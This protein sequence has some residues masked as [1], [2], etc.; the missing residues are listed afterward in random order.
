MYIAEFCIGEPA[1]ILPGNGET[2]GN[3]LAVAKAA[4]AGTAFGRDFQARPFKSCQDRF[5]C[6]CRHRI[7]IK[8]DMHGER[9]ALCL[10]VAQSDAVCLFFDAAEGQAERGELLI[11]KGVHCLRAAHHD[12]IIPGNI[13]LK[14][15][16]ADKTA[17]VSL[18]LFVAED[19]NDFDLIRN[20]RIEFFFE[21]QV[22]FR[23]CSVKDG[24]FVSVR[25]VGDRLRHAVKRGDTAPSGDGDHMIRVL[26]RLITELPGRISQNKG[27]PHRRTVKQ[28]AA[29]EAAF[30]DGER[31]AAGER[32]FRRG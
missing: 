4:S 2:A 5:P 22:A 26:D 10:G 24:K 23:P 12:R 3:Q 9:I 30:F 7:G 32:L 1:L 14:Q 25:S 21:D 20:E 16:R 31:N 18:L 17:L 27:I 19:V 8:A 15:F 6:I 29:E 13:F 11:R 28:I